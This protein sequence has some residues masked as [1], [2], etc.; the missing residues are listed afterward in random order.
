MLPEDVSNGTALPSQVVRTAA[1]QTLVSLAA[2]AGPSAAVADDVAVPQSVPQPMTQM[3]ATGRV[4]YSRFLEFVEEQ[5]C[6]A[7]QRK[8]FDNLSLDRLIQC[9]TFLCCNK[10]LILYH[11]SQPTG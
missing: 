3:Q 7:S 10:Y 11:E 1:V 8:Y 4:T 6:R 5:G 2:M 9:I